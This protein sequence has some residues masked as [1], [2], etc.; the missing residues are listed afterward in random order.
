MTDYP[1][2]SGVLL[3]KVTRPKTRE[4]YPF[5]ALDVGD[6]FFVP[7]A[8]RSLYATAWAQSNRLERVF[9]LRA[10]TMS[11]TR[12]GW[13]TCKPGT[14]GAVSGVGVWRVV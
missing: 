10:T 8:T 3:P 11:K 12:N 2:M 5:A 4:S 7:D 6:M 1:I 9:T 13:R 14:E